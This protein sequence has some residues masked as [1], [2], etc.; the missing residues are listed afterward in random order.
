MR[1]LAHTFALLSISSL[2]FTVERRIGREDVTTAYPAELADEYR[3]TLALL[4]SDLLSEGSWLALGGASLLLGVATGAVLVRSGPARSLNSP[5]VL[6]GR[7]R[8]RVAGEGAP[9][10]GQR[11]PRLWLAA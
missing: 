8:L 3:S 1:F 6:F 5:F 2:A 9:W 11:P 7:A 4:E 10:P